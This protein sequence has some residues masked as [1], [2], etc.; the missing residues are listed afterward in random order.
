MSQV[1]AGLRWRCGGRG[2]DPGWLLSASRAPA[3]TDSRR[4]DSVLPA[5]HQPPATRQQTA[6]CFTPHAAIISWHA[7]CYCT[8]AAG[9][10][11][12]LGMLTEM[13]LAN[14]C[15]CQRLCV[16]GQDVLAVLDNAGERGGSSSSPAAPSLSQ[17]RW[18]VSLEWHQGSRAALRHAAVAVLERKVWHNQEQWLPRMDA[19]V[20]VATQGAALRRRWQ[21]SAGGSNGSAALSRRDV[22]VRAGRRGAAVRAIGLEALSACFDDICRM[23]D[24]F[25]QPGEAAHVLAAHPLPH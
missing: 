8:C 16:L 15:N 18:G 14:H 2:Q 9:V 11:F 7:C 12:N 17:G 13:V 5:S 10:I 22:C 24:A 3:A 4:T 21:T 19:A 23:V 1:S 6:S 25:T 20:E